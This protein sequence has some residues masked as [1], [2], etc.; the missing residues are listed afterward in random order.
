VVL[1]RLERDSRGVGRFTI[2]KREDEMLPASD[3]TY[4]Y[5]PE[6]L[7]MMGAAFDTVC[8]AFPP[9]MRE[10]E[11]ARR[12]LALLIL[13]HVDRGERDAARLSEVALL[14]FMR[15]LASGQG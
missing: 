14:D 9:N 1:F 6:A 11:A 13:R 12:K 5:D 8:E 2:A 15:P 3:L 7:K 4:V 10:H